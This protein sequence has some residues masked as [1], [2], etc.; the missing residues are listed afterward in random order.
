MKLTL[1]RH[2]TTEGNLRRLYYG[3]TD[4]PL[5][6]CGIDDLLSLKSKGGYPA[7]M[8]Y[9]TSGMRRTEE[10]LSLLYGDV[11][12]DILPGLAEMDFGEFEMHAYEELREN[13]RYQAWISGDIEANVCP[14]GESGVQVTARALRELQPLL[15][16]DTDAA[17]ITH[18]G[19][20]A[21]LMAIWFEGGNRSTWTPHPGHGFEIEFLGGIPRTWRSIP[22]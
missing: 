17:C 16:A 14:G 18:G 5:A 3:K 13:P 9:Y 22:K 20:I 10:T 6:P 1:I 11:P 8:Q 12:H 4:L 2:G 15:K 7:A 19:V 21:G